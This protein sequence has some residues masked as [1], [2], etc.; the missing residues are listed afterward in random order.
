[1]NNDHFDPTAPLVDLLP[2]RWKRAKQRADVFRRYLEIESPSMA[3][4]A[5]FAAEL[6]LARTRFRVLART[7]SELRAARS[8]KRGENRQRIDPKV[9]DEIAKALERLGTDARQEDLHAV[10]AA[11]CRRKGLPEPSYAT[12]RRRLLDVR[13]GIVRLGRASGRIVLD[14]V[15][16]GV[17]VEQEGAHLRPVLVAAVDERSGDV[18]G[19]DVD[20]GASRALQGAR[21]LAHAG[22]ATGPDVAEAT[23]GDGFR[24][25]SAG[26][27]PLISRLGRNVGR[28]PV[29]GPD[30]TIHAKTPTDV[31]VELQDVRSVVD[32]VLSSK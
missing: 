16:L 5:K 4:T 1:M 10:A 30:G 12:V 24:W 2:N 28:I 17:L 21:A 26:H 15:E 6:G 27:R 18:H 7:Y 23:D 13:A 14:N 8:D 29:I 25:V 22:I 19:W 11:A 9:D 31:L 20:A 3:E 32:A